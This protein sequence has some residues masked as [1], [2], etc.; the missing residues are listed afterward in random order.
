MKHLPQA[1]IGLWP[2]QMECDGKISLG[3]SV[4]GT[5]PRQE[6]DLNF[7]KQK[8]WRGILFIHLFIY[9]KGTAR[10]NGQLM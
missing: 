6:E 5:L 8:K 4:L 3:L 10:I 1:L 2:M 9:L 7:N